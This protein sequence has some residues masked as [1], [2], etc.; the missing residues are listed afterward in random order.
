MGYSVLKYDKTSNSK[1]SV[2]NILGRENK[3]MKLNVP[4]HI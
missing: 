3:F 2:S 1:E 4:T